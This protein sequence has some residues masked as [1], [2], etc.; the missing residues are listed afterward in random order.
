MTKAN[1]YDLYESRHRPPYI[2]FRVLSLRRTTLVFSASHAGAQYLANRYAAFRE[3]VRTSLLGIDDPGFMSPP[4]NDGVFRIL[5]CSFLVPVK[6]VDLAIRGLAET[7]RTF[8]ERRF[9][10]THIG[11][12]PEKGALMSLAASTL[13]A[14]VAHEFLDYPGKEGLKRYYRANPVDVFI[15][16][17]SSEGTSVAI[18]E[19]I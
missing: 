10:W 15:N 5:S 1:G 6:R 11:D 19:A 18:M 13:P 7:G 4:S 14:N 9:H 12:G 16:T 8:P 17:S 2:P 3:K